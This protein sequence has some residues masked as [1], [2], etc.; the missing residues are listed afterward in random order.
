MTSPIGFPLRKLGKLPPRQDHRTLCLAHYLGAKRALP[1]PPPIVDWNTH[2]AAT[3]LGMMQN[4]QVGNCAYAAQAHAV[5]TWTANSRSMVTVSDDAVI[6]AYKVTGYVPGDSSTDRGTIMLDALNQWRKDG[7][8]GHKI[9]GYVKVDHHNLLHVR[10]A[11]LLFGGLYV[12]AQL[13]LSAQDT[14]K[15]WIGR[16]GKLHGDDV[17]GSWGGHALWKCRATSSGPMAP[18]TPGGRFVTWGAYQPYDWQ[19]WLNYT[20]EAYAVFGYDWLNAARV[21]PNGLDVLA[22]EDDLAALGAL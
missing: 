22:L 11:V 10:I 20:D 4:D 18:M 5:Q 13:P 16:R 17:P 15:P 1:T 19:W 21:A 8:G 2:I 7:I 9:A 6:D 12:G 14:S 3:E